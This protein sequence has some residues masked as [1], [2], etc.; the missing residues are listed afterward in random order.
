M[1]TDRAHPKVFA[2]QYV[3]GGVMDNP[4]FGAWVAIDAFFAA[5]LRH[6][7]VLSLPGRVRQRPPGVGTDVLRPRGQA[8][9][10]RELS[11]PEDPLILLWLGRISATDKA[12][13]SPLV[14]AFADPAQYAKV[15]GLE[16]RLM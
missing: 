2:S 14:H 4:I 16:R 15:M 3:G 11:L 6:G 9:A 8:L 10:R 12:D 1:A 7:T 13:L 5:I